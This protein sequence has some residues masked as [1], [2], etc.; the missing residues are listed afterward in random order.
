MNP[1]RALLV[2]Y[3]LFCAALLG[4]IGYSSLAMLSG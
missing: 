3:N 4:L 2:V 1:L